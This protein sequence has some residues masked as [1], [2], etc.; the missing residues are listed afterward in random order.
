[1]EIVKAE[2]KEMKAVGEFELKSMVVSQTRGDEFGI[3]FLGEEGQ[4]KLAFAF[5]KAKKAISS[6]KRLK[7][8]LGV[9]Y[10][11]EKD[12]LNIASMEEEEKEES[13]EKQKKGIGTMAN[14]KRDVNVK[15]LCRNAIDN[16]IA[17]EDILAEIAAVYTDEGKDEK[18]ANGRARSVYSSICK[19]KGLAPPKRKKR[20]KKAETVEATEGGTEAGN[21]TDESTRIPDEIAES[22]PETPAENVD[23]VEA[24][25]TPADNVESTEGTEP[26]T[27]ETPDVQG[28][29]EAET[30]EAEA[31]TEGAEAET[32]EVQG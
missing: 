16:K 2:G 7:K 30:E 20:G 21:V 14:K 15:Q 18:Y 26:P 13:V 12:V 29:S 25:E 3:Y 17:A 9:Q 23:T 19:E 32:E 10:N 5:S 28:E 1:V 24:P 4:R 31:Q 11:I 22:A 6:I 8:D 27:E